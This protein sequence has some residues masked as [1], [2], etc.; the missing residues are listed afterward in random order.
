MMQ[1][2]S[3]WI[4]HVKTIF[5]S[6]LPRGVSMTILVS[7]IAVRLL[8]CLLLAFD[9]RSDAQVMFECV[10]QF[11]HPILKITAQVH[12]LVIRQPQRDG[13]VFLAGDQNRENTFFILLS[14]LI[15]RLTHSELFESGE[16]RTIMPSAPRIERSIS[17]SQAGEPRIKF[18]IPTQTLMPRP[19]N[20]ATILCCR[21]TSSR[22]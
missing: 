4:L 19:R 17:L 6:G 1:T 21:T 22:L 16:S 13:I 15:S 5:P 18:S 2:S 3:P 20:S 12:A 8:R 14:K 7:V 9:H 10:C 11:I